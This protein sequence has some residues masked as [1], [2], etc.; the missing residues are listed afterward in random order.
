MFLSRLIQQ[1]GFAA[2]VIGPWSFAPGQT[3]ATKPNIVLIVADDVG[4]SDFACYGGEIR[5][6]NI[7]R[8]ARQGLRFTQFYNNATCVPT[9]ASLYTGLYPRYVGE[10]HRI[11][12]TPEMPTLAELLRGAG[13]GTSLSG[14]WHLG[15]QAPHHPLDRGFEVYC[16]LLD[17]CCN[18]F[19]PARRDRCPA[20]A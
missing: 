16:G 5:T 8:L 2:A 9:R 1:I 14:K 20:G 18:Y 13:Y 7:D 10:S 15:R 4:Y 6:P 3:A 19:D 17:G 11:E 12:L